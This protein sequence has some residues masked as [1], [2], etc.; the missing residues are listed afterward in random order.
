MN[1]KKA[2]KSDWTNMVTKRK[3]K[4]VPC[5]ERECG[6]RTAF[7]VCRRSSCCT[8]PAPPGG[9]VGGDIRGLGSS[10]EVAAVVAAAPSVVVCVAAPCL[11]EDG[12]RL[13]LSSHEYTC[14]C[15]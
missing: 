11:K 9:G 6:V 1:N 13:I 2:E 5:G 3:A 4:A 14:H 10:R 8:A 12:T 7:R 15:S